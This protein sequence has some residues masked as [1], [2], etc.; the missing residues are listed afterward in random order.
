MN[1][2]FGEQAQLHFYVVILISVLAMK[3]LV[4]PNSVHSIVHRKMSVAERSRRSRASG[5]GR[6]SKLPQLAG[7]GDY[8]E[9]LV[10]FVRTLPYRTHGRVTEDARLHASL[11]LHRINIQSLR[12]SGL[13]A[14]AVDLR[15]MPSRATRRSRAEKHSYADSLQYGTAWKRCSSTGYLLTQIQSS[16]AALSALLYLRAKLELSV[17]WACLG[18]SSAR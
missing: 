3:L 15:Q 6:Q 4:P 2:G 18:Y 13:I 5:L 17:A 14:R 1:S 12:Y 16:L 11:P 8:D 9:P 10:S 7:R